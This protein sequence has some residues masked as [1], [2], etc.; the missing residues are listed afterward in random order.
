[1]VVPPGNEGSDGPQL[2]SPLPRVAPAPERTGRGVGRG[3]PRPRGR[4]GLAGLGVAARLRPSLRHPRRRGPRRGAVRPVLGLG[5]RADRDPSQPVVRRRPDLPAGLPPPGADDRLPRHYRRGV[6]AVA[7][8]RSGP[9][10]RRA[11]RRALHGGPRVGLDPRRGGGGH[12][13]SRRPHGHG[14]LDAHGQRCQV[15]R[16]PHRPRPHRAAGR[17]GGAGAAQPARLAGRARRAPGARARP[18]G[19]AGRG[20]RAGPHRAGDARRGL[21]QH[22]GDGDAGRRRLDGAGLGPGA[23]RGGDPGGLEHGAPGPDRHAA[24]ARRA[25]GGAGGGCVAGGGV[26]ANGNGRPS[27]APQPGLRE[28]DA[29]VERVRGTGLDVTVGAPARPSR[30]RARRG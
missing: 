1:M 2:T 20:D 9:G 14:A 11:P 8:H 21:A 5:H 18:A 15:L 30:S 7:R 23:R 17:G 3:A 25:A 24:P 19:V 4:R 13:R 16:V 26:A 29:L 12:P 22:P 10:R 27:F 28:L 6:R